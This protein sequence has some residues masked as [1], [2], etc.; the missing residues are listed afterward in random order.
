M[1]FFRPP[2]RQERR[3]DFPPP[4]WVAPPLY[5]PGE[6]VPLRGVVARSERAAVVLRFA[7]AY[8]TGYQLDLAV[9]IRD[10]DRHIDVIG[11][12]RGP[13]WDREEIPDEV[14]GLGIELPDGTKAT[15][16]DRPPAVPGPA[17]DLSFRV[18]GG[19]GGA[20]WDFKAWAYPLPL[21]MSVNLVRE[22]PEFKI[23]LTHYPIDGE[24]IRTAATRS[25]PLW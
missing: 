19:G 5:E 8:S 14:L 6:L 23:P 22:W 13:L 17:P 12:R 18:S 2:E 16:L 9:H 7:I 24:E 15:N 11:A 4:P 25:T 10:A 20:S 21:T 3:D 1:N